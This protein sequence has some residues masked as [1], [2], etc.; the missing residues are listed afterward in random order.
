LDRATN[1]ELC[2]ILNPLILAKI[3]AAEN[4][5][6]SIPIRRASHAIDHDDVIAAVDLRL[7]LKRPGEPPSAPQDQWRS[8]DTA[9]KEFTVSPSLAPVDGRVA[10]TAT[11]VENLPRAF[12]SSLWLPLLVRMG[13]A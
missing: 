1:R 10:M 11:S 6:S 4:Q 8:S 2:A 13:T 9:E 3:A 5:R 12:R 7:C